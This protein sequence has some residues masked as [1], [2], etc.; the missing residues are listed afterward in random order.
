MGAAGE[1]VPVQSRVV[2]QVWGRLAGSGGFAAILSKA[3][4]REPVCAQ[5]P[6]GVWERASQVEVKALK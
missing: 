1:L 2:K 6:E 4:K 3:A 5:R